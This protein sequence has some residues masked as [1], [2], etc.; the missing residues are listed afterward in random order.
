MRLTELHLFRYI[1]KKF[2]S[3]HLNK[4]FSLQNLFSGRKRKDGYV[5]IYYRL[6]PC[7]SE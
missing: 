1:S 6:D 5:A 7:C 4:S 2:R 3:F